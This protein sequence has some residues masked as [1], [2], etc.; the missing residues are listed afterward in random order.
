MEKENVLEIEITKINNDW[1]AIT[2]K[3]IK[4]D[5]GNN[6]LFEWIN[7]GGNYLYDGKIFINRIYPH[8]PFLIR[9]EIIEKLED[10][11]NAVNQKY[12][13]PKRWRAERGEKYFSVVSTGGVGYFLEYYGKYDNDRYDLGNYFKTKEQAQKVVGSQEWQNFWAK[14]R[15][16]EI[17]GDE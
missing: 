5:F 17:G 9:N 7:I 2:I 6:D 11:V 14:V 8:I 13:I 16:G 4:K 1:S 12:G 10:V 15:A 3:K